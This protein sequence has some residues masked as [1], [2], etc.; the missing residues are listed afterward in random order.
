MNGMYVQREGLFLQRGMVAVS[1]CDIIIIITRRHRATG[2]MSGNDL[3]LYGGFGIGSKE[4][5]DLRMFNIS[6]C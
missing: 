6:T 5:G 2:I 3:V 1:M 4:L